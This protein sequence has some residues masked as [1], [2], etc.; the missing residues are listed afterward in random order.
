[1]KEIRIRKSCKASGI[2]I[3]SQR[4]VNSRI[5]AEMKAQELESDLIFEETGDTISDLEKAGTGE[6]WTPIIMTQPPNSPDVNINDLG[7]FIL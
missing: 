4:T 2:S 3:C 5:A 7:F 1:M 6:G